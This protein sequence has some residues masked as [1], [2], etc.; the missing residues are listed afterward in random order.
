MV[1][2]VLFPLLLPLSPFPTSERFSESARGLTRDRAPGVKA[3]DV[4]LE[5]QTA[6]VETAAGSPLDYATVLE[7]IKKTGKTVNSGREDGREMAV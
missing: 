4:S 6:R 1:P 7:K 2:I 5:A 3:Y